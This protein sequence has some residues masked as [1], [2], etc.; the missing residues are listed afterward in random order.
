[1]RRRRPSRGPLDH[2]QPPSR[3]TDRPLI[4]PGFPQHG[5][6]PLDRRHGLRNKPL[7]DPRP[8][9]RNHWHRPSHNYTLPPFFKQRSSHQCRRLRTVAPRP[10]TLQIRRGEPHYALAHR[11]LLLP[12]PPSLSRPDNPR[13]PRHPLRFRWDFPTAIKLR[14][15]GVYAVLHEVQYVSR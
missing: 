14:C 11:E 10:D 8:P 13:I 2:G 7:A 12:R 3:L 15:S 1:M 4:R 6:L 9:Q 5:A